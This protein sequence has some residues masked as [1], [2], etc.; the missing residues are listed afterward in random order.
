ML[1]IIIPVLNEENI[2]KEKKSYF[3][4][5]KN[6]AHLIFVDGGSGDRT[7]EMAGQYGKIISSQPGRGIQKNEGVLHAHSENLLF[8]NVDTSID[9][10]TIDKIMEAFGRGIYAGCLKMTIDHPAKPFKLFAEI[11]NFRGKYCGIIDAD[12]GMFIKKAT[13][14][15]TGRF[16]PLP[17]MEDITFSKK[18]KKY[19]KPVML[20]ESIHV[21]SRK[22]HEQGFLKT[23]FCYLWAYIQLW[24]GQ[25][26]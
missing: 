23:F 25:L 9:I 4:M 17:Y 14:E 3:N 12:L 5:L 8:L 13:F 24:I 16:E 7:V 20:P 11:I 2:L 6:K 21:S 19:L 22:W 26:K 18:L 10:T 15:T 1:D